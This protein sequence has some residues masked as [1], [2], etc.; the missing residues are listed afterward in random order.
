[1]FDHIVH[2]GF[3][4]CCGYNNYCGPLLSRYIHKRQL[5]LGDYIIHLLH[6]C[7]KVGKVGDFGL[8]YNYS[9]STKQA[10]NDPI[11]FVEGR[12]YYCP[13][14]S[15]YSLAVYAT[16]DDSHYGLHACKVLSTCTWTLSG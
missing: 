8:T 9:V 2:C 12:F 4:V 14:P 16:G 1:M 6:E 5:L 7:K 11:G 3:I 13:F 10:M 15:A